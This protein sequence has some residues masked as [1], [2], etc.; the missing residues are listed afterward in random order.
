MHVADLLHLQAPL[1]A[2]GVVDAPSDKE[3]VMY[4]GELAGKPLK[5]L[6]V[7]QHFADLIRQRQK[8]R[9][10][11]LIIRLVDGSP[12]KG[13]MDRHQIAGRQLRAVRLRSRH[14]D[15]R[16]R[17]CI[18]HIIRLSGNARAHHVDH[19]QRADPPVFRLPKRRQAVGGFPGLADNH[20]Q[21]I[22]LQNR[23]A[24]AE[25]RCQIHFHRKPYQILDHIF[26]RDPHMV[27]ASAG[28]DIE[29]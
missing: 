9:H 4:V 21:R 12:H 6:L 11:F 2:D 15:L 22:F 16:A 24:V 19:R 3:D 27:G 23:I 1:Q 17:Q 10:Q 20:H 25:F 18:E 13:E 5:P 8:L 29:S 28:D 14:R 7:L 26:G